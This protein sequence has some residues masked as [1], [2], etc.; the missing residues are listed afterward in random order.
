MKSYLQLIAVLILI[1]IISNCRG[2]FAPPGGSEEQPESIPKETKGKYEPLGQAEDYAIVSREVSFE[3]VAD[4][5]INQDGENPLLINSA[6]SSVFD[7]DRVFRIQLF[8]AKEYGPAIREKNIAVEVFDQP[9]TMDYEVPYYKI[10]VG[11]FRTREDAE[12]YLPAAREAGYKTAWVVR[13]YVN[14]KTLE[15][16]YDGYDEE[17]LKPLDSAELLEMEYKSEDEK[18]EYQED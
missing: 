16:V 9:I 10:R 4:S 3:Q 7:G 1:L 6:D 8:T 13:A 2:T 5:S 15:E 11:D 12:N 14:V 18:I 17:I